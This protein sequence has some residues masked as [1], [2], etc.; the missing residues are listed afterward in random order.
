MVVYL[1]INVADL[2][3]PNQKNFVIKRLSIG[4]MIVIA[5]VVNEALHVAAQ[6]AKEN[7]SVA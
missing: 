7:D 1:V 2:S 5:I 6:V 4:L 3:N